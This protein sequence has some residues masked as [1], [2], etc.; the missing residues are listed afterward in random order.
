MTVVL[1]S[2]E[3]TLIVADFDNFTQQNISYP[4]PPPTH[5][6]LTEKGQGWY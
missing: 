6:P 3:K 4:P 5:T 1:E 2:L